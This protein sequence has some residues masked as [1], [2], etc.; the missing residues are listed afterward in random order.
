MMILIGAILLVLGV[1]AEHSG[2]PAFD[3]VWIGIAITFVGF[4]LWNKLREKQR[5]TRFSLFRKRRREDKED[6]EES[7]EDHWYD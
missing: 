7:W 6:Q 2:H 4:L 3:M 5:N 1:A